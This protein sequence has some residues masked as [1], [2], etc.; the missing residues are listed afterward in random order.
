[1]CT[2]QFVLAD[3]SVTPNFEMFGVVLISGALMADSVV[4]NMQESLFA[5]GATLTEAVTW[6]NLVSSSLSCCAILV[7]DDVFLAVRYVGFFS[8]CAVSTGCYL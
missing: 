2:W 7:T 6:S 3:A 1:M 8:R 4:G 5:Q